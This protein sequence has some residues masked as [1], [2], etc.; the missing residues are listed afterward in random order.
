MGAELDFIIVE[1][2]LS[3]PEI[4][5]RWAK[6]VEQSAY[7]YGHAGYTGKIAEM[8]PDKI[9]WKDEEFES[10]KMAEEFLWDEHPKWEPAWAVKYI[11][12]VDKK[13]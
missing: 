5:E 6:S 4:M 10:Y 8:P 9:T 11:K 1:S 12:L 13:L 7:D 2:E 3:K